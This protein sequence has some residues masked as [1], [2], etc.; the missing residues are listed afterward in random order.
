MI[1]AWC[2]ACCLAAALA[3]PAI[4]VRL[5][6][7]EPLLV[8]AAVSTQGA[9]DE[10]L[11]AW[12]APDG[13]TARAAFAASSQLARQIEAG[14]PADLVI[15]ADERWMDALAS[16][17]LIAPGTRTDLLG[18]H[19]VLIAP[20]GRSIAIQVAPG[21]AIADAFSGRMA[22]TDPSVPLGRY[23]RQAFAALG[24]W[25]ALAPR[26]LPAEDAHAALR[27]VE[28]GDVALG[29]AYSSDALGDDRVT[30]VAALPDRLHTP[31]RYPVAVLSGARPM[32]RTLLAW[33]VSAPARAIFRRHGFDIP[34]LER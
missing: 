31:I 27:L 11:R 20:A 9:I 22:I 19:L 32:A 17:A 23:A 10:A 30:V 5:E 1:R 34:G 21:F 14:A 26:S 6:A 16:R 3:L 12:P 33:L 4:A 7:A 28:L 18:N 13:W 29:V 24:W 2:F 15:S 25:P 8:F